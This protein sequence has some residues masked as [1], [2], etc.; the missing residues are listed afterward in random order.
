VQDRES[1]LALVPFA[2]PAKIRIR[3]LQD[4]TENFQVCAAIPFGWHQWPDP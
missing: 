1:R 4:Q 3:A 2:T